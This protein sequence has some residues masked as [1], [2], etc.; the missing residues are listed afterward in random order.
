MSQAKQFTMVLSGVIIIIDIKIHGLLFT[1]FFTEVIGKH[2]F[3]MAFY[4]KNVFQKQS[5]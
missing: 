3:Y 4:M 5:A 2:G 1:I